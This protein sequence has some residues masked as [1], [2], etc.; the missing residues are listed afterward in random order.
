[1][2]KAKQLTLAL[3]FTQY[4]WVLGPSGLSF[5]HSGTKGELIFLHMKLLQGDQ[6]QVYEV[7]ERKK[8]DV[9][10]AI[11]FTLLQYCTTGKISRPT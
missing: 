7:S 2:L 11:V 9:I 3:G 5:K 10:H 8:K 6:P 4:F 1:M